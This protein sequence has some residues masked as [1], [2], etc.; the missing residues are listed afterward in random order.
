MCKGDNILCPK[1]VKETVLVVHN[2]KNLVFFDFVVFTRPFYKG[3]SI[4]ILEKL[5]GLKHLCFSRWTQGVFM[6]N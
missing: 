4:E 2:D 5:E 6:N 1:S 3:D